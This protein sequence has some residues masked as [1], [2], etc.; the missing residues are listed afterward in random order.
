[1]HYKAPD[2]SLHVLDDAN[3]E[4]LLPT[5]SVA[6]TDEEAETLRPV[7]PAPT[8][9]DLRAAAYPSIGDQVD[10]LWHMIDNGETF[11]KT[12]SFY[13]MIKTVK[14]TYPKSS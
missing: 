12:S 3:F 10:A 6:I 2:H 8:Y 5:G 14:D 1:M 13:T 7:P 4:H 11:D 9:A